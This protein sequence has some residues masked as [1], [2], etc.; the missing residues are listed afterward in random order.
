MVKAEEHSSAF[1]SVH[2]KKYLPITVANGMVK[3][4]V[5][6]SAIL[7]WQWGMGGAS[8]IFGVNGLVRLDSTDYQC[9]ASRVLLPPIQPIHGE[10]STSCRFAD[11][12]RLGLARMYALEEAIA[13]GSLSPGDVGLSI[14]A[15]ASIHLSGQL[16]EVQAGANPRRCAY[17]CCQPSC[18]S[19]TLQMVPASHPARDVGTEGKARLDVV[20]D[21]NLTIGMVLQYTKPR[22]GTMRTHQTKSAKSLAKGIYRPIS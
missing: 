11:Q 4:L 13:Q 17:F 12:F 6:P 8:R 19:P 16:R 14:C 22:G 1:S 9:R 18:F 7:Y 5:G 3:W 2:M 15:V 20:L 21:Q 10:T